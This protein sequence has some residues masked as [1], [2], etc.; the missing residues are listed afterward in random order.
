MKVWRAASAELEATLRGHTSVIT[1][2][3]V[4]RSDT[5]L[6]A[7]ADTASVE[8]SAVPP[9]H[10]IRIWNLRHSPPVPLTVLIGHSALVNFIG[11]LDARTPPSSAQQEYLTSVSDDGT[12]RVWPM[13]AMNEPPA[14][15]A[16]FTERSF[17]PFRTASAEAT[18][19]VGRAA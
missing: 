17:A 6:A 19:R 7:A 15:A 13:P 9:E 16:P 10:I 11:F 18:A 12:C 3:S 14:C 2:L 5:L 8:D 4:N 1:D